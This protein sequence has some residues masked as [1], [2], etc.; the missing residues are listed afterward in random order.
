MRC[1]DIL[2]SEKRCAMDFSHKFATPTLEYHHTLTDSP[3]PEK[4]DKHCHTTYEILYVVSG[5]GKYVTEGREYPLLP[6]TLLF[7]RPYEFHCVKPDSSEPYER[8]VLNFDYNIPKWD[9]SFKAMLK[10][11]NKEGVGIYYTKEGTDK[12]LPGAFSMLDFI[13]NVLLQGSVDVSRIQL[14]LESVITQVLLLLFASK[15]KDSAGR[16]NKTF[17]SIIEYI[18]DNLTQDISLDSI[19]KQFYISKYHLCRTF[20]RHTGV[21]PFAYITAKRIALAQNL[22]NAGEHATSV[23]YKVGFTDYS[24]FYRAY[25]KQTGHSPQAR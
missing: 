18:N 6:G 25:K 1:C 15:A 13:D 21:S 22:I 16:E 19:S 5:S 9:H 17:F 4:F 12:A 14:M 2:K 24:A 11:G 20:L 23:A 7:Q 8:Y 3:N 10:T